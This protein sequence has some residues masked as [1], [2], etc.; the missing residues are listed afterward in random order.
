MAA[1][2]MV[3][4]KLFAV[5]ADGNLYVLDLQDGQSSKK[6]LQTI[7]LAGRLWSQ[8]ATDGK[9]VYITSLDH[10]VFAVDVETY[11]V[12]WHEDLGGAIP[13]SM[14][15]GPD[16]MLYVGSLAS[17]LEK[18]DPATGNHQS[19]LDAENWIWST[20]AGK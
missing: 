19:V 3:N 1:P 12:L 15:L 9:R 20:P 10:S 14:V 2:L 7:E 8:P 13:G 17:H 16:G 18:F 5:N 6:A 11:K 4:N